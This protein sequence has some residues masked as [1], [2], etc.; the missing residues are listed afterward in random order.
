MKIVQLINALG[1]GGAEVFVAQLAVAL[2]RDKNNEV[3][4]ITYAGILDDKENFCIII[5]SKIMSII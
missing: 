5:L 3:Y 4:V 1:G 2:A